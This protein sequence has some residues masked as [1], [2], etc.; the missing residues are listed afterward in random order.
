MQPNT[1]ADWYRIGGM[2]TLTL[3]TLAGLATEIIH[4]YQA[5]F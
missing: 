4:L 1:M 5:G 3:A 2:V